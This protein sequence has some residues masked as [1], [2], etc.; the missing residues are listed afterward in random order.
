MGQE[1]HW[2]ENPDFEDEDDPE[3]ACKHCDALCEADDDDDGIPAPSGEAL[4]ED[5]PSVRVMP[6]QF[7]TEE[8]R[9][10]LMNA[11]GRILG[12][13]AP[14]DP[15][16]EDKTYLD[17][18]GSMVS[19]RSYGLVSLSREEDYAID[20]IKDRP[21]RIHQVCP[22]CREAYMVKTGDRP[23]EM[24]AF[25]NVGLVARRARLM[26]K[27]PDVTAHLAVLSFDGLNELHEDLERRGE[28]MLTR[29][30]EVKDFADQR[31]AREI[32]LGGNHE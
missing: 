8:Q 11:W 19:D 4:R 10:G 3:F 30:R 25:A 17:H 28:Q 18:I 5:A 24:E 21:I 9:R 2:I 32:D 23:S 26:H 15:V 22:A 14:A 6:R 13:G 16:V 27:C 20:E 31:R 29:S 7:L 1:H 12:R